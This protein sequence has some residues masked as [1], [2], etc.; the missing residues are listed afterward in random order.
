M[1]YVLVSLILFG[2]ASSQKLAKDEVDVLRAVAKVLHRNN[3]DFS[4]DPCDVSSTVGGWR[5]PDAGKDFTNNVTCDCSS[6]V[7]HVT[8]M[9]VTLSLYSL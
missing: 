2:F 8:S 1:M 9:C 4:V 5:T 7:W 3:W 6:S